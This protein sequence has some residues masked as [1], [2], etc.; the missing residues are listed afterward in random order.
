MNQANKITKEETR[1]STEV[2]LQRDCTCP[3]SQPPV[4]FPFRCLCSSQPADSPDKTTHG[5]ESPQD[6]SC[7]SILCP[8]LG[9]HPQLFVTPNTDMQDPQSRCEETCPAH[10][11]L[12]PSPTHLQNK[13]Q[14]FLMFSS[15][16][17]LH[18]GQEVHLTAPGSTGEPGR[19]AGCE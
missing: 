11:W 7:S 3:L 19:T 9:K 5:V 2:E 12:S 13:R 8:S 1:S 16:L 17:L 4:P 15:Y 14:R 6:P 10:P 18:A